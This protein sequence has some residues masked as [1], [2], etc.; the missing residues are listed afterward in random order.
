MTF[1][2]LNNDLCAESKKLFWNI[3]QNSLENTC[4]DHFLTKLQALGMFVCLQSNVS[5][6]HFLA[7]LPYLKKNSL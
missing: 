3:K 1:R 2:I 7:L 4:D 5:K 6:E